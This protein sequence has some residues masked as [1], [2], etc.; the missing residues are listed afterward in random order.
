MRQEPV[1]L[2]LGRVLVLVETQ[3]LAGRILALVLAG[4]ALAVALDRTRVHGRSVAASR[5]NRTVSV[6]V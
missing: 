6:P 5:R 4:L 2:V 3:G 1:M